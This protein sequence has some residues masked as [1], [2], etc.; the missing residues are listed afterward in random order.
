MYFLLFVLLIFVISGILLFLRPVI[1]SFIL[2]TDHDEIH[3]TGCWLYPFLKVSVHIKNAPVLSVFL[4]HRKIY[5]KPVKRKK[6]KDFKRSFQ[7]LHLT[8]TYLKVNYGLNN[9]FYTG[10]MYS[11]I[12]MIQSFLH[13]ES[14]SQIP[15]FLPNKEYVI[16]NAGAKLWI[17]KTILNDLRTKF[18][19]KRKKRREYIGSI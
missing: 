9:P 19:G 5:S 11:V 1:I 10:T 3:A 18:P 4:F 7:S 15:D 12:G 2:D 17:G 14:I 8:N 16:V 6:K 13:I